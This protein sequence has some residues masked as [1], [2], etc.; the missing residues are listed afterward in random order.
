MYEKLALELTALAFCFNVSVLYGKLKLSV[1]RCVRK[2]RRLL[3]IDDGI[4]NNT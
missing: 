1:T 3:A 4:N 2:N